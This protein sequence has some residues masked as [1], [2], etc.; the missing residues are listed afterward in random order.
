MAQSFRE[1]SGISLVELLIAV[2]LLGMVSVAALQFIRLSE[3]SLFGEQTQLTK[4][5][6]SEAISAHIYKKFASGTLAEPVAAGVYQDPDMPQDLRDSASMTLVALFGNSSRFDGVDPRCTLVSEANVTSGTFQIRH[7]CMMRAGQGIVQQMNGLISKGVGLTTGLEEGVGRCS[8]SKPI[9]IDLSSGIAT[10]SVDDPGCLVYGLDMARGV[11]VGNQVLLPRFVAYDTAVPA[12]FHTSM[13]EPPDVAT[14]G[15]GL[16]MPD[17]Y[18]VVGHGDLNVIGFVDA[19]ANNPQTDVFLELKTNVAMSRLSLQNAPGT[20]R[21]MGAGTSKLSIE[22]RLTD[23][24]SALQKLE[25]RS[26]KGYMGEDILTGKLRSGSLVNSDN[27]TLNVG[28]NCGGQRCGTG[29]RFDFGEFNTKTGFTIREYVI[30][31][32]V[33]GS[34]LP[35]TYY[36]YCG[37]KFKFDRA[38]G[39]ERRYPAG[40]KDPHLKECALASEMKPGDP[41]YNAKKSP[42]FP[43]VLYAPKSHDVKHPGMQRPDHVNVFLYEQTS[44]NLSQSLV[45][46]LK[47][48]TEN[49]FS[50]FF[51]FDTFDDTPGSVSFRLNNIEKGRVLS[52]KTDPFTFLDDT[53]EFFPKVHPKTGQLL[54]EAELKAAKLSTSLPTKIGPDGRLTSRV[55]WLK[56]SDGLVLPLRLGAGARNPV[57]GRYELSGY[58]HDPDGDGVVDP[59]LEMLGWTSLTGWNIRA[60]A[61]DGQSVIYKQ[62]PFNWGKAD[63]KTDIQLKISESQNCS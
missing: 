57:T 60:T 61:D 42:H 58:D 10:V 38:D 52:E 62:I 13:I 2:A 20:V 16:E 34:E 27:T 22:G 5:K 31:V 33:C 40:V 25:Y 46:T 63:Q 24:R 12:S 19:L 1:H 54:S 30:S 21:M 7:D 18:F 53:T 8:I 47:P 44:T 9:S 49:R 37:T 11:P 55:R 59:N 35:S 56:P 23:V 41:V 51:Q 45:N 48:T 14:A 4:Q 26:P 36:G 6:R 43:Y 3:S 28:V 17:E 39:L 29:T 15:I 50:L 32:S